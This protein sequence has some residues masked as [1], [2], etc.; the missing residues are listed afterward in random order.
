M[1]DKEYEA[2]LNTLRIEWG[3]L[4]VDPDR[5]GILRSYNDPMTGVLVGARAPLFAEIVNRALEFRP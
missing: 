5:P 2:A 4:R 3:G 1:T